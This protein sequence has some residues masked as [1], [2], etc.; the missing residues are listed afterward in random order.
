MK[1]LFYDID[2]DYNDK[3]ILIENIIKRSIKFQTEKIIDDLKKR[4]DI[5]PT[6][7]DIN[8][9]VPHTIYD[10][11]EEEL[12]IF[13]RLRNPI[14]WGKKH[15]ETVNRVFFILTKSRKMLNRLLAEL[16]IFIQNKKG[17]I[18]EKN[19]NSFKI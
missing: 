2:N 12:L 6:I 14:Y 8:I 11:L 1:K 17:N 4:E 19:F 16:A 18:N 15:S 3:N 10:G 7:L 9:G 5:S 13:I